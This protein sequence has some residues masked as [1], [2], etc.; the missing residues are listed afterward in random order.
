M[1]AGDAPAFSIDDAATT[2]IDDAFSVIFRPD[3]SVRLG[4]HIAA[5]ALGLTPG[6]DLDRVAATRLSTVYMPGGKITMLPEDL[7]AQYT[8][9]ENRDCPALS[10]YV[11]VAPD[12]SIQSLTTQAD[13]VRIAANLRHETLEPLFNEASIGADGPD[14]PFRRE[15]EW[16]HSLALRL[17]A[18]RGKA[19]QIQRH[20]YVFKVDGERVEIVPRV[21]GNPIDKVV[22]EL[23]ILANSRWGALLAER[24]VAG[25]Y[26]AQ[27]AGKVRMTLKP[28]PHEGLGVAHY[29]WSTSPL[30]RYVDLVNQRQILAVARGEKPPHAGNDPMLFAAVRDFELAYDA[31]AEFQRRM[32]RFWCLR[33]LQQEKVAEADAT[34]WREN[35]IRFDNLPLVAKVTGA[36]TL[37][38]GDRVR[39]A[40]EAIDLLD[41]DLAC[42]YLAPSNA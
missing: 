41:I 2:E 27:T 17:E 31:Y 6:S 22:S 28:A 40:V 39:V 26:R 33:W 13:M 34:V 18:D 20:D 14:Y 24:D 10:L 36:P 23:M 15:L 35:L 37:N 7:I 12:L 25:V 3:G 19:D 32:E 30:R 21:R 38:P 29:T 11:E 9:A 4:I 8:L 5:P 16:L 1:P 42:R